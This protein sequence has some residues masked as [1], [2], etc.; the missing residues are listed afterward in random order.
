MTQELK[1]CMEIMHQSLVMM[2]KSLDNTTKIAEDAIENTAN[3]A[4][5]LSALIVTMV[6]AS[7]LAFLFMVYMIYGYEFSVENIN[8][9]S[10]QT[11]IGIEID[12]GD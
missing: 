3:I 7:F 12:K 2:N 9:N 5:L 6:I 1:D 11:E 8:D 10:N 4:K